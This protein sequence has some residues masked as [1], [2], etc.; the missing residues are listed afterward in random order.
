MCPRWHRVL[1]ATPSLWKDYYLIAPGRL[2]GR[3]SAEDQ[4]EWLHATLRQLRRVSPYVESLIVEDTANVDVM[5]DVLHSLAA[6]SL[7]W[8]SLSSYAVPLT[9]AA[10]RALASLTLLQY[11]AMSG[12][13]PPNLSWALAQLT[14][15]RALDLDS[16]Q[17][18]A[19]LPAP[20]ARLP[21]LTS[22]MLQTEGPLPDMQPLSALGQLQQLKLHEDRTGTGLVAL[23]AAHFPRLM[24]TAF[25][26]PCL[27]VRVRLHARD[28]Q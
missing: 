2:E 6:S 22:L 17:L 20:L 8:I 1:H 25:E 18:P 11:A 16:N 14:G 27:K 15:L 10:L 12:A 21:H 7:T 19:D 23:P 24:H 26:S 28:A 5:P 9:A 3:W 13:M 4:E